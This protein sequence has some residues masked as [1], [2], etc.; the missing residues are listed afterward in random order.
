MGTI[1]ERFN[2]DYTYTVFEGSIESMAVDKAR[3]LVAIAGL[4]R[5]VVLRLVH[6]SNRGELNL[7]HVAELNLIYSLV[8]L[9][10]QTSDPPMLEPGRHALAK[11]VV[12]FN[13]G[14]SVMVGYLDSKQM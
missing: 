10:F 9:E 11:E 5:V 6:S 3:S 12:F 14:R 1:Q 7:L 4:G 2:F 8:S 13:S